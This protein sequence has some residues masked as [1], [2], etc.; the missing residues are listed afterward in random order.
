MSP[1]CLAAAKSVWAAVPD[2]A[3][4]AVPPPARP[5]GHALLPGCLELPPAAGAC[6]CLRAQEKGNAR[7]VSR[8]IGCY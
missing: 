7:F 5:Q 3:E 4:G 6:N 2:T 8:G 1:S